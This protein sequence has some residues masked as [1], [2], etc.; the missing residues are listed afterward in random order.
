[1]EVHHAVYISG[2]MVWEYDITTLRALCRP[3]HEWRQQREEAFRYALGTIFRCLQPEQ[4]EDEV[5]RILE[6]IRTRETARLAEAFS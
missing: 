4:I 3:C 6:E 1:M 2:R 5:W